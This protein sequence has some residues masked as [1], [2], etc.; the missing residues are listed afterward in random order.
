MRHP[1]RTTFR[2]LAIA[3]IAAVT[4]TACGGRTSKPVSAELSGRLQTILDSGVANPK[5]VFPAAAVYVSQPRLGTWVGAA[6]IAD[7]GAESRMKAED[8]FR[9]GS[10]MKPFVAVVIL[11][12]VEEGKLSLDDRLPT[13]LPK[14]VTARFPNA[15]LIT[16]RMLL[17]HT[18]G[19][20]NYTG[21][22]FDHE[23]LAHPHRRWRVN[24]LLDLA[25]AKQ[26]T[27]A[28]GAAFAYSNTNY[29]LLGLVIERVTGEP[30]RTAVR[31]RIIQR[32]GLEHTSL[33]DPG[34]PFTGGVSAHGYQPLNGKLRDV[35]DIDPSM[36]DAAGGD[37]LV[38][39]TADLAH[40]LNELLAG[41]LFAHSTTLDEMLTFVKASDGEGLVGYGLGL[42]RYE[43][44]GGVAMI[45]HVGSTAG[46]FAF[47]G[48]LPAQKIDMAM[49]ITTSEYS[50]AVLIPTLQLMVDEASR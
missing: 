37:A 45:G 43:L 6:G 1:S 11:Q 36:A 24:D 23:V 39:S 31:T 33:P 25:A 48:R 18:S 15:R 4:L 14:R 27:N 30:W 5:T 20:P 46:Y 8:T 47:M 49:V 16:L 41:K 44:P 35:T 26:S 3:A 40:F 17:N 19:I 29:N 22:A 32:I 28:P 9:A 12:L 34:H 7:V 13:V 2:V 38:T 10:I 42:E 21:P 50:P